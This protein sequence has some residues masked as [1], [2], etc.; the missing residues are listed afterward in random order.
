MVT[1][2][3]SFPFKI[4]SGFMAGYF[5]TIIFHQLAVSIFWGIGAIPFRPYSM[6]PTIPFGIPGVLSLSFWGGVWGIIF[7]F[8]Y[9]KIPVINNFWLKAFLFGGI[10]PP[11]AGIFIVGPLKGR[12]VGTGLTPMFILLIFVINGIWG[13]GTG[14]FIKIL[15]SIRGK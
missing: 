4:L 5:S 1:D 10:F 6:D 9:N 11:I 7:M 8:V 2:K 12:P 15:P 14:F 13:A 3:L